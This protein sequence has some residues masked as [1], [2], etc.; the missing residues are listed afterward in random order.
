MQAEKFKG[1]FVRKQLFS[2][3]HGGQGFVVLRK[4]VQDSKVDELEN[5]VDV[6][7]TKWF[8]IENRGLN[9]TPPSPM[10]HPISSVFTLTYYLFSFFDRFGSHFSKE[11]DGF[12]PSSRSLIF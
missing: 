11:M 1:C 4:L 9:P 5:S 10:T 2:D 8:E 6:A 7:N 12:S 3:L